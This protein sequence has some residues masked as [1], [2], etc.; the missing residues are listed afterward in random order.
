MPCGKPVD[1]RTVRVL[2]EAST[3]AYKLGL[4]ILGDS[5]LKKALELYDELAEKETKMHRGKLIAV[6]PRLLERLKVST[7]DLISYRD[8]YLDADGRYY[9]EDHHLH[10]EE[11]DEVI[12]ENKRAISEAEGGT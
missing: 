12:E 2:A 6:A 4:P 5:A 3:S 11:L 8:A 9:D 7:E 10:V 1:F